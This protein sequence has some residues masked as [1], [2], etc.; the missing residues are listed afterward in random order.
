M[1]VSSP[2]CTVLDMDVVGAGSVDAVAFVMTDAGFT[3][4]STRS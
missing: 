2:A 3:E 1:V 4:P